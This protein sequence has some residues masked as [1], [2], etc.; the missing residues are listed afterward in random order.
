MANT[1]KFGASE[2]YGSEGNI[3]AYNDTNNNFKPLP[4]DFSRGSIATVINKQGLI[5][6]VQANNARVDYLDNA[7]GALLLEPQRTNFFTYSEDFENYFNISEI[8]LNSN[9]AI[10]PDGTLNANKVTFPSTSNSMYKSGLSLSGTHTISF[11][12]K[13]EGSNIG[14]TFN[15]RLFSSAAE[16]NIKVTLESGWKRFESQNN[17]LQTFEITN[18]N[19]TTIG[20]GSLLLYGFQ[21]EQGSFATSLIKTQGTAQTRLVDNCKIVNSPI[22]QATNQFTLF[23]DSKDFVNYGATFANIR[24]TLG[25]GEG[26]YDAGTGIHIHNTTW[27]Y[28]NGSSALALGTCYN[29]ITDRKFAISYNGSKYTTYSNGVKITETVCS[30]SMVNWDTLTQGSLSYNG[31][32]RIFNISDLK[33]YNTALTDEQLVA[34]TTI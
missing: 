13:G 3:L 11:W 34:L 16:Q 31:V 17:G 9:Y 21:I 23:F 8:T 1:L 24:I 28:F 20:T 30:A 2:W 32:D 29:A 4:F 25:A 19:T 14:K 6:T 15:V 5:E 18:R 26:P 7:K 33:L 22:L 12:Y 10:S 27:Y